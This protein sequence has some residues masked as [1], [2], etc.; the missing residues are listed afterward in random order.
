M[1]WTPVDGKTISEPCCAIAAQFT[2]SSMCGRSSTATKEEVRTLSEKVTVA[3]IPVEDVQVHLLVLALLGVAKRIREERI[4]VVGIEEH[5]DEG[6]E[7][8]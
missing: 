6:G 5:D 1:T 7:D 2:N 8:V 4:E 3:G